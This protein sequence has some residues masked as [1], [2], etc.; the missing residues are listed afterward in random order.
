MQI[1][2]VGYSR[3]N[4]DHLLA[5][6]LLTDAVDRL[7]AHLP[8]RSSVT[9]VSGLTSMGIPKLA[10]ELADRLGM[11]TLGV[12]AMQAFTVHCGVYPVSR[13]IIHGQLF[14]EESPIFIDS[15]EYLIRIGGG[16]QS[17]NEVRLFTEK[18]AAQG[19]PLAERLLEHELPLLPGA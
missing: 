19:W 4:F 1:G 12:S 5:E 10:Y 3:S 16:K 2:V 14:G 6:K 9:I 17:R 8:D 18:C 7:T 15:I 13:Q 11:V